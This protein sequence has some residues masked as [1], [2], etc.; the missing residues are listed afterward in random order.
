MEFLDGKEQTEQPDREAIDRREQIRR[1][2]TQLADL[3]ARLPRHSVPAA[4][5]LALEE[6]EEKLALLRASADLPRGTDW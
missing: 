5:L 2:E 3:T 1:L 6:M 4:M